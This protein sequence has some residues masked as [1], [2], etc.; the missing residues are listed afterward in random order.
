MVCKINLASGVVVL[1]T[2]VTASAAH[3]YAVYFDQ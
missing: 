1:A 3:R 2:A